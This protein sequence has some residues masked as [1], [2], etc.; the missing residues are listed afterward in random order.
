MLYYLCVKYSSPKVLLLTLFCSYSEVVGV[1][2]MT[3]MTAKLSNAS[4][5]GSDP[6]SKVMFKKVET[7]R[8]QYPCMIS[9]LSPE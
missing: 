4:V 3:E 7:V 2:S 6:I 8:N 1:A 5:N 9:V